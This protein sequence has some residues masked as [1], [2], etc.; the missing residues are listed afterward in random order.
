MKQKAKTDKVVFWSLTPKDDLDLQIY[1]QA[2][3]YAFERKDVHNIAIS[4]AYG[5]GK[6]SIIASY[7]KTHQR[8][9]FMH[10]S[11]A[12]YQPI[13]EKD[14]DEKVDENTLE[15]K[16]LNQL[17]HQIPAKRIP[18][19]GFRVKRPIT[20][21]RTLFWT[22]IVAGFSMAMLYVVL[23]AKWISFAKSL[24]GYLPVC[25]M[26]LIDIS[27]K[28]SV[29]LLALGLCV[30]LAIFMLQKAINVQR[31]KSVLKKVSIQGNEIEL[32][33]NEVDSFFD[34]YLNE[35]RYLF[36]NVGV[37]AIVFED[38]DRFNMESIFERLHEVNI[39]VNLRR[40][41]NPLRFIYLLR[42]DIYKTKDRTKFFDFIIPV[43][44]VIDGSNSYNKL[45]E[46]LEKAELINE[47]D[48]AFLQ[49]VS[50][51]IDD[52]RL[53]Q[54]I[55]NEFIIYY[56]QLKST[57]PNANNMLAMI[58]YKNLFPRDF[59][60]LQLGRGYV[61]SLFANKEKLIEKRKEELENKIEADDTRI[62]EIEDEVAQSEGEIDKI[63]SYGY[64][65]YRSSKENAEIASRKQLVRERKAGYV[66]E[67]RDAII[68]AKKDLADL[69]QANLSE[70]LTRDNIEQ[71]MVQSEH[72]KRFGDVLSNEYF[73]LLKYL[74]RN[75]YVAETY[76]DY[77]TYFYE[78]NISVADKTFLRSITDQ[79][80]KGYTHPLRNVAIVLKRMRDIDFDQIESLNYDLFTCMLQQRSNNLPRYIAMMQKNKAT[81]F[82]TGYFSKK[83]MIPE[84]IE[85]LGKYW[86]EFTPQAIEN[87]WFDKVS[88]KEYSVN[89]LLHLDTEKLLA[90]NEKECLTSYVSKVPDYLRIDNPDVEKLIDSLKTINV[91]FE[92]IAEDMAEKNLLN[93]VYQNCMYALNAGNITVMLHSQYGIYDDEIIKHQN[94]AAIMSKADSPMANYVQE[95]IEAYMQLYL[96]NCGGFIDDPEMYM[97]KILNDNDITLETKVKYLRL[98]RNLITDI[99]RITCIEC[100]DAVLENDVVAFSEHNVLA[101]YFQKKQISPLL[102]DFI[103]KTTAMINC[104]EIQNEY[105]STELM[106]FFKAMLQNDRVSDDAFENWIIGMFSV[107]K[108]EHIVSQVGTTLNATKTYVLFNHDIIPMTVEGLTFVRT[109]Y[110]QHIRYFVGRRIKEYLAI[111]NK[112]LFDHEEM[113]QILTWPEIKDGDKLALL[114]YASQPIKIIQ[115]DYSESIIQYIV[116]HNFDTSELEECLLEYSNYGS[117]LRNML[118]EIAVVHSDIVIPIVHKLDAELINKLLNC[119]MDLNVRVNYIIEL[120][121]IWRQD[122]ILDKLDKWGLNEY[123]R[124][125]TPRA[126]KTILINSVSSELLGAFQRAKWIDSYSKDSGNANLYRIE[127]PKKKQ[128]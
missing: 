1:E 64:Y 47:F 93:A 55:V 53:L 109:H 97:I 105:Q 22:M 42:D 18:Q 73:P 119:E 122:Q 26:T 77:M 65:G 34:R 92:S 125:L 67:L 116:K 106:T 100:W 95:N 120:M 14:G 118:V 104:T 72:A 56:S 20:F 117:E 39:L 25:L 30:L 63:Y 29:R 7:K 21:G 102:L 35:V 32:A 99:Q 52:M 69:S 124:L 12:H 23:F 76:S 107:L 111:M 86:P 75:G 74:V 15:L 83:R 54:N 41:K 114:K 58:T 13:I 101:I 44:P 24:S 91:K 96:E 70:L 113:L 50:L 60:D 110:D 88:L 27:T 31:L 48:D 121:E 6:S 89:V 9:K 85:Y 49:G 36:E 59:S 38:M 4:G 2:L 126:P 98:T 71:F 115:K 112:D 80:A 11:L 82:V 94:Y 46:M 84:Y 57:E 17:V 10:I 8:L 3:D 79:E 128:K 43:I 66:S 40:K 19:T 28:P 37:D 45:K 103:N 87:G 123:R 16:I 68:D 78:G 61:A 5:A 81:D 62:K 33:N 90:V 108:D 51:Y 127:L